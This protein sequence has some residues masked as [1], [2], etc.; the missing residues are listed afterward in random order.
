MEVILL[1]Q[2]SILM[3]FCANNVGTCRR[4]NVL[5]TYCD[6]PDICKTPKKCEILAWSSSVRNLEKASP[7][8]P[9]IRL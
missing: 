4:E 5:Y 7:V 2:N 6:I 1:K 9:W 8:P 3:R